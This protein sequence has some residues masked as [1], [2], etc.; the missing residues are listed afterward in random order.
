MKLDTE[1]TDPFG[2]V[3]PDE[4][5]MGYKANRARANSPEG[6]NPQVAFEPLTVRKAVV[7][8]LTRLY[9]DEPNL[10]PAEKFRRGEIAT[11]FVA[12]KSPK[13]GAPELEL[14][15]ELTAKLWTPLIVYQVWTGLEK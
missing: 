11:R 1:I 14:I 7:H 9:Q 3:Y 2:Q 5:E 6:V 10:A 12:N 13:I 15:Q 4:I 8:A